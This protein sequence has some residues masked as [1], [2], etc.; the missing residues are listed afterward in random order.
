ML[1]TQEKQFYELIKIQSWLPGAIFF[2]IITPD[3]QFNT[4]E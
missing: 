4:I 3:S 1:V 2:P